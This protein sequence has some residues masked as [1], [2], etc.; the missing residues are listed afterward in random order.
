[1]T[2]SILVLFLIKYTNKYLPVKTGRK[3]AAVNGINGWRFNIYR[4]DKQQ[5][6]AALSR[7]HMLKTLKSCRSPHLFEHLL[8]AKYNPSQYYIY[9]GLGSQKLNFRLSVTMC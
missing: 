6:C 2:V 1:M 5:A 8:Y 7:E 9:I 4:I 3:L